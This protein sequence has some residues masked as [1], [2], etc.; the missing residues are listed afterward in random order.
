[1][2]KSLV[3]VVRRFD[4]SARSVPLARHFVLESVGDTSS[5]IHAAIAVMVSELAT[6]AVVHARTPFEVT[7]AV[8]RGECAGW[9]RVDVRDF[10]EGSPEPVIPPPRDDRRGRGLFIV[11]SLADEWGIT[12]SNASP[13]KVVWFRVSL[14]LTAKKNFPGGASSESQ[15]VNPTR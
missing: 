14:D 10:G 7:V 12:D 15:T 5:S 4:A 11:K 1:M 9:A 2:S 13:G 6:N 3:I 8:E